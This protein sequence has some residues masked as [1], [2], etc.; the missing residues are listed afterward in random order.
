LTILRRGTGWKVHRASA[1]LVGC[2]LTLGVIALP[3]PAVAEPDTD[4]AAARGRQITATRIGP[5]WS[6]FLPGIL[7]E[8]GH[9]AFGLPDPEAGGGAFRAALW[10]RGEVIELTPDFP[11]GVSSQAR[12]VNDRGE[13]VGYVFDGPDR[14]LSTGFR[15]SDG[16]LALLPD[17][18]GDSSSAEDIDRRGRV[19]VNRWGDDGNRASVLHR[20]REVFSP[21]VLDGLP[22]DGVAINDRGQVI[23]NAA[24]SDRQIER[25]FLWEPGRQPIDLGTL[26][27]PTIPTEV[28]ATAVN[29]AGTVIGTWAQVIDNTYRV[30]RFIWRDGHMTDLGTLGGDESP[31]TNSADGGRD[32]LNERDQ[33]TGQSETATGEH[34]AFLWSEGTMRD[35]GTLGGPGSV[36]LAINDRGEVAGVSNTAAGPASAFLWRDGEMIDLGALSGVPGEGFATAINDR[37]QVIGSTSDGEALHLV[38]WE[39][40]NRGA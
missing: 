24:D 6:G 28:H 5:P 12:A 25:A 27:D 21:L 11:F 20:G 10:F 18:P 19:L 9:V 17:G 15:W 1:C 2:L 31:T 4:P 38:L 13:V 26:G 16:G 7:S 40:R 23:G 39:T 34:H 30:R 14:Y 36:G 22:I 3:S 37:G 32:Q 8:R 35:L 33:V 29:N